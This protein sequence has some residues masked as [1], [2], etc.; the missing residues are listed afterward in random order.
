M[1]QQAREMIIHRVK[2]ALFEAHPISKQWIIAL[3]ILFVLII[4]GFTVNE[5]HIW[6][7]DWRQGYHAW[8]NC[9]TVSNSR[10]QSVE[11]WRWVEGREIRCY[12]PYGMT[13]RRV[14]ETVK[15][16]EGLV[17]ELKLDLHVR[18]L[19]MPAR[20]ALAIT[21][22]SQT[23]EHNTVNFE[24]L[25]QE[26]VTT[27]D[28]RYAEMIITPCDLDQSSDTL[29]MANFRYG[30][31]VLDSRVA[32]GFLARHETGHLLGYNM[33]DNL[34]FIVFGYSNHA[35][36]QKRHAGGAYLMMPQ[37]VG[38]QLSPQ[39][40]DALIYF[41]VGLAARTHQQYFVR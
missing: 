3:V 24:K 37:L 25:C 41:W 8:Y 2:I 21:H 40:R 16:V 10:G 36:A 15:G 26:L 22:S 19:P 17:L 31:S 11:A 1:T 34:P 18:V 39:S 14:E 30:V 29:G 7:L 23:G 13:P 5:K 35:I 33:H 12:T 38:D 32:N 27:R 4:A 9:H 28:G 20:V 6:R